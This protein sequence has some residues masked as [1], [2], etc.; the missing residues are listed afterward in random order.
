ML[1]LALW[2]SGSLALGAGT[3]YWWGPGKLAAEDGKHTLCEKSVQ[4]YLVPTMPAFSQYR[5]R[6]F[7]QQVLQRMYQQTAM[8]GI[9]FAARS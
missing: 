4:E 8:T 3:R 5:S 1:V 6:P 9:D 7:R 2:L